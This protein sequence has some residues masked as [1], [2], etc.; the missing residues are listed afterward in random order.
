ME[1][2]MWKC[3]KCAEKIEDEFD[4]CWSCGTDR[5][6]KL[7]DN[8]VVQQIK[9]TKVEQQ[10]EQLKE[11]EN[12]LSNRTIKLNDVVIVDVQI[13]FWSMVVLMVKSA[14]AAIPALFIVWIVILMFTTI[15]GGL[16][17]VIR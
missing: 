12:Q 15:F 9:N 2:L 3:K 11:N 13:P 5:D 4:A 6:G 7:I 17:G 1:L 14:F 8:D 16:F 10:Q